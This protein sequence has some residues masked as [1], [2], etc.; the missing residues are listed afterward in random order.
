MD[1]YESAIESPNESTV[2]GL[3]AW[4]A[5]VKNGS[6]LLRFVVERSTASKRGDKGTSKITIRMMEITEARSFIKK[7][8]SV[9]HAGKVILAC[10]RIVRQF[11]SE[12]DP[13]GACIVTI[14]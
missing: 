3:A 14:K 9:S 12:A 10:D 5:T 8:S 4:S 2:T 1:L 7:C 13:P 11:C 6:R